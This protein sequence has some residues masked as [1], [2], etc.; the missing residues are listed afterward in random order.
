[1]TESGHSWN[2]DLNELILE[3]EIGRGAFGVVFKG[4]WRAIDGKN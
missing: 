1:M 2:I 3:K 4:T